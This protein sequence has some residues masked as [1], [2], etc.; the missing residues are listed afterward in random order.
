M[1]F[2]KSNIGQENCKTGMLNQIILNM[3]IKVAIFSNT[4]NS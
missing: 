1:Q 4:H 3:D 2:I